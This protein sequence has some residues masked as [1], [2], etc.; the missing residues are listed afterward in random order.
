MYS[1]CYCRHFYSVCDWFACKF[2]YS[3]RRKMSVNCKRGCN[4]LWLRK[5]IMFAFTKLSP[6]CVGGKLI[7]NRNY[8]LLAPL[9][10]NAPK[11][12]C[13]SE[14]KNLIVIIIIEWISY[15][16][17]CTN[18]EHQIIRWIWHVCLCTKSLFTK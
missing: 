1:I 14:A 10:Q 6:H 4:A 5:A 8:L 16:I 13:S 15:W 12:G 17:P 2:I 3:N 9:D 11:C 7:E 18:F